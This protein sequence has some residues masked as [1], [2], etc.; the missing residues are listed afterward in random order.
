MMPNGS[1]NLN[2][3]T[4]AAEQSLQ[5]KLNHLPARTLLGSTLMQRRTQGYEPTEQEIIDATL[6]AITYQKAC[7]TL[8]ERLEGLRPIPARMDC[9]EYGL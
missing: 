1:A 5:A 7:Q 2:H 3:K 4:A 8:A 9:P 6:D